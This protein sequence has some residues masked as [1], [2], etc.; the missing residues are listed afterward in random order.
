MSTEHKQSDIAEVRDQLSLDFADGEYLNVIGQNLG[1]DRPILGFDDDQWRALVKT[2]ALEYKQIANKFRDV[3]EVVFGPR[4]TEVATLAEDVELGDAFC[5]LNETSNLP[6]V[7]TLVFDEGLLTEET[8]AYCL[9]DRIT[10]KVFLE[11]SFGVAHIAREFDSEEPLVAVSDADELIFLKTNSF[12]TVSDP[13]LASDYPYPIVVGRGTDSEE[14]ILVTNNDIATA[15]LT[16]STSPTFSHALVRASDISDQL[17]QPYFTTSSVLLLED[18]SLFPEE[19]ILKLYPTDSFTATATGAGLTDRTITCAASS[20]VD[21]SLIGYEIVFDGNVTAVLEGHTKR[22]VS[23]TDAVITVAVDFTDNT[24]IPDIND[25]FTIRPIVQYTS[26]D[27]DTHTVTLRKPILQSFTIPQNSKVELM[28]SEETAALSPVKFAGTGWD[29]IQSTPR[30]VEL[31]LPEDIRDPNDLRSSSHIHDDTLGAIST[32]NS[33]QVDPGDTTVTAVSWAAFPA[34]GTLE[35]DPG[36]GT[37]ERIAY[38]TPISEVAT[39]AAAGSGTLTLQDSSQF[40]ASGSVLID[41]GTAIEETVVYVANDTSTNILTLSGTLSYGHTEGQVVKCLT[42]LL[43]QSAAINTH[44]IGTTVD[45][46]QPLYVTVPIGDFN[47]AVDTFPGPYV[48]DLGERAV[49]ATAASTNTSTLIPG[50]SLLQISQVQ[51]NEVFEIGDALP[52]VEAFGGSIF[53][54]T[55]GLGTAAEELIQVNSVALK[56][57]AVTTLAA[58]SLIGDFAI[59]LTSLAP[60]LAI[61]GAAFP[62]ARGYRVVI[63]EAVALDREVA[64]VLGTGPVVDATAAIGAGA[65]GTVNI[66]AD[67]DLA[68][69]AGNAA[70]VEVVDPTPT[71][72]PLTVVESPAGIILVTLAVS[73]GTLQTAANTAFL[74]AQAID[75]DLD[76]FSALHSGTGASSI[77][78]P[79]GPTS[80]TGGLDGLL[81]EE[82]LTKAHTSGDSV[83]LMSD[84]VVAETITKSHQ[85]AVA[86]SLRATALVDPAPWIDATAAIG[87]GVDGTVNITAVEALAGFAGN[88]ATVEVVD[89]APTNGPLTVVESPAGIITVTLAVAGGV[90]DTAANTA[91]LVAAAI[92]ALDDFSAL[93]SGT[94]ATSL[95]LDEGPT[96]FTGGLDNAEAYYLTKDPLSA[97]LAAPRV[98][99][100][101]VVSSTGLDIDGGYVWLNFGNGQLPV[102]STLDAPMIATATTAS[103]VSSDDFPSPTSSFTATIGVG[104]RTEEKVLVTANN[105]G[106]DV[107]TLAGGTYGVQYAHATGEIVRFEPGGEEVVQYSEIDT[108]DLRFSPEIVLQYTHYP[109][110]SVIDSSATSDPRTNGYDFPLRMPV[111]ILVRLEYL[112]DIVRAAGVQ[113]ELIIKR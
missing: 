15:T 103:L 76:D 112:L 41:P 91:L 43:L 95:T 109:A 6:Q 40:P 78:A 54:L 71:D 3:L 93:H 52:M 48:Y 59:A 68:G 90:L 34:A 108:N 83:A 102:E 45:F 36:G 11:G 14:V 63:D 28:V 74:I 26:L 39:L 29:I 22:I 30:L 38:G 64:Y 16:L 17:N 42:Q 13:P 107:L 32:T 72:G 62:D 37:A 98:D 60:G 19:G 47:Q 18:S 75:D 113:V 12:P 10:N 61:E 79:E 81:L 111:D 35:F 65:D 85:G 27:Y 25:T 51:G 46:Y 82:A 96:S 21:S 94:G 1:L 23:N 8:L 69:L 53:D 31:L 24:D 110:E 70:T 99:S 67:G 89:P 66:T 9:I 55:V 2:L 100:I 105:T 33:V 87:A 56:N 7:G 101:T 5:F 106:T 50:S 58:N 86:N 49:T 92:D 57:R 73:G 84:L 97:E 77:A 104:L 20:F 88:S 44:T 80:F 4:I